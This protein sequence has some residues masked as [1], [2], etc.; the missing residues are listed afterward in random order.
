VTLSQVGTVPAAPAASRNP[1]DAGAL[2]YL[3]KSMPKAQLVAVVETAAQGDVLLAPALTARLL[4]RHVT[5]AGRADDAGR[6]L[7]RL[8]PR[9]REVLERVARGLSNDEIAQEL[10]LAP[11]T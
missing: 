5:A 1:A 8:T 9:E 2:G 7:E 6:V 4:S 3:P 11:A 10:F